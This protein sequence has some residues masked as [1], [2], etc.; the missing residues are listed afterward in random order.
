M[1]DEILLRMAQLGK[2]ETT[3]SKKAMKNDFKI[4][5]KKLD[6]DIFRKSVLVSFNCEKFETALID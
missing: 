6:T 5:K 2:T 3:S 1:W 4:S